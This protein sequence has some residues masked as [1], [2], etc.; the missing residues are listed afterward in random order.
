MDG[1]RIYSVNALTCTVFSN[2]SSFRF[3]NYMW[4][5]KN[6]FLQIYLQLDIEQSDITIKCT[7]CKKKKTVKIYKIT[8]QSALADSRR[9]KIRR[10]GGNIYLH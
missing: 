6:I 8:I 10:A 4:D 2:G 5:L 9:L 7:G 3:L 1:Y